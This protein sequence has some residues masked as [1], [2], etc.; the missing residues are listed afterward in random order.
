[1][2]HKDVLVRRLAHPIWLLHD[3][4]KSVG[5]VE[6]DLDLTGT[7]REWVKRPRAE[8]TSSKTRVTIAE[9]GIRA[10]AE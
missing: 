3:E 7:A 2:E 6:R 10:T 4:A 8:R 1:M 9:R 5:K